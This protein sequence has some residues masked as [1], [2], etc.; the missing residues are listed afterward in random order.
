[1]PSVRIIFRLSSPLKLLT[2]KF[3]FIVRSGRLPINYHHALKYLLWFLTFFSKKV[4]NW[5]LLQI[6][7]FLRNLTHRSTWHAVTLTE[8][9]W[10]E[11]AYVTQDMSQ[12]AQTFNPLIAF[13]HAYVGKL[14]N[15]FLCG[16]SSKSIQIY[17]L[18]PNVWGAQITC[19]PTLRLMNFD[20]IRLLLFSVLTLLF[21]YTLQWKRNVTNQ[22]T[23]MA[24]LVQMSP[25]QICA[26]PLGTFRHEWGHKMLERT[27]LS[28]LRY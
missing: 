27:A 18:P 6:E 21:L 14:L 25:R 17:N 26:Y 8:S 1:M 16:T 23:P 5:S 20:C 19:V 22:S 13:I 4:Y 24:H 7:Q 9:Q 15:A 28:G 10:T 3:H 12:H 2:P 11:A